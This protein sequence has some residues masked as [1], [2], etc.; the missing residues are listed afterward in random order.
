MD[1]DLGV[2]LG[3]Y[4]LGALAVGAA[5]GIILTQNLLHAVLY[6]VLCFIALAGL[7]LTLTADF[8]AVAQVLI[9][10]GAVGVLV[11][12]AV[13][14]T[15][16]SSRVNADTAFFGPG[17]IL[18]GL[19]AAIMA[20]VAFETPWN[21]AEGGGFEATVAAIGEGLTNRWALPF[22]IA[23]V[24]LIAAMI[25]AIVLVRASEEPEGL[26]T[27]GG[28]ADQPTM[29]IAEPQTGDRALVPTGGER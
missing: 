27:E 22:E 25:G 13:M 9:Y 1:Q 3:F 21:T 6:L 14:L 18:G 12:F 17:L 15:P 11:I 20:F 8:I 10:A 4:G 26:D 24:L 19:I 16:R 23:S 5:L 28:I 2:A 7:F 29:D